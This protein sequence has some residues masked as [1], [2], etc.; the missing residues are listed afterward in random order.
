MVY[1]RAIR[2]HQWV[3]NLLVFVPSL[4]A[5][6]LGPD[7]PYAVLAFASFSLCA[8]SV[9]VLNDL[10]DLD[11]DRSHPE[12]R[13]RPFA[14]GLLPLRHGRILVPALFLA[15]LAL[16]AGEPIAF[17][18]VLS[19][20][21]AVTLA[22]TFWLK[23][24]MIVDVVVLT[25]LFGA[26]LAAGSA[27]M[28]VPLSPWLLAF[29]FFLFL[30]LAL[31]KR[32]TELIHRIAAGGA[33]APC[34]GYLPTDLPVLQGMAAAAG[35]VAVL[36]LALYINSPTVAELYRRPQLLWLICVILL[37]W[38]SRILVLTHRGEMHDDPVVFATI[39]PVSLASI[40]LAGAILVAAI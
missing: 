37:T 4:A 13:H 6:R 17:V 33:N 25:C 15:S 23:R 39:D 21:F 36:V 20:Y 11:D 40:G 28:S 9:Y 30:S 27:A 31:T 24:W 2:V 38:I 8:S 35:Y 12:K 7:W 18:V 19:C 10:V 22:Y 32:C 34:R 26:R 3:K 1:L 5:H 14:S 16:A 29:S